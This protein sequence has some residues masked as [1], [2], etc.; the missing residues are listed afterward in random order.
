MRGKM[1]GLISFSRPWNKSLLPDNQYFSGRMFQ[2]VLRKKNVIRAACAAAALFLSGDAIAQELDDPVVNRFGQAGLFYSQSAKTL[3]IGRL[4]F[5][6]Y[7]NLSLDNNFVDHARAQIK[8][9]TVLLPKASQYNIMP[10]LAFGI[11]D[12]LDFSASLPLYIDNMERYDSLAMGKGYGGVRG[13]WAIWSCRSNCSCLL[14]RAR[15]S[16][17]WHIF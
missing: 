7:G 5:S 3:G 6:A 12:F 11:V 10:S 9:D 13:G 17:I 16:L 1:G 8:P 14:V 15:E 4:V 2:T